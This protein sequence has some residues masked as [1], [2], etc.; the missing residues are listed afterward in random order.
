[1]NDS[2]IENFLKGDGLWSEVLSPRSETN[3]RAALFLDRDGVMVE[4]V[5]Y[6]HR[7]RDV[8]IIPGALEVIRRA[9]ERA[10][11]VVLV[12]NQAGIGRRYYD[13]KH[14]VA[15]QARITGELGN[16]GTRLDAV[17]ACPH[18]AEARPPYQHPDHPARKP[19]PGM[20]LM[21]EGA[22]GIDLAKSWIVG[23]R[24]IDVRAGRN[25]G[26]AGGVHVATGHGSRGN[27]RETALAL[28]TG[29]FRVLGA[30]SVAALFETPEILNGALV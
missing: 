16:S 20:M 26:C 10:I 3:G 8:R 24:A 1:M 23:D 19:N 17:F 29:D 2:G 14:F 28:A 13:W 9:N 30:P 4:E 25:A 12:T 5:N 27:E 21:A 15:V 6:L 7:A 22:L 18:H 11:C